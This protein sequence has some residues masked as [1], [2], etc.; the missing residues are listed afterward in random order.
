M[1]ILIISIAAV[2]ALMFTIMLLLA[3]LYS[4]QGSKSMD[5][6]EEIL[7]R[8]IERQLKISKGLFAYIHRKE[9]S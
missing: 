9:K 4:R 6:S 2:A 3:V 8:S 5:R 1:Q 7:R